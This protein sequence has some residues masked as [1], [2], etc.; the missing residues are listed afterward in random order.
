VH[1]PPP[2]QTPHLCSTNVRLAPYPH[3]LEPDAVGAQAVGAQAVGAQAAAR[4][5]CTTLGAKGGS[6]THSTE[7]RGPPRRLAHR[8]W[9]ALHEPFLND[10]SFDP[11]NG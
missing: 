6:K 4:K 8:P 1:G 11:A 10:S 2:S 7:A 9:D 5:V 3:P